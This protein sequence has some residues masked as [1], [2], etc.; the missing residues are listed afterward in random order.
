MLTTTLCEAGRGGINAC[1]RQAATTRSR[2]SSERWRTDQHSIE[3]RIG[4]ATILVSNIADGWS[5]DAERDLALAEELVLEAP[6]ARPRRFTPLSIRIFHQINHIPIEFCSSSG[7][8]GVLGSPQ[9]PRER[10]RAFNQF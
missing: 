1:L 10:A 9:V 3:T 8:E 4:L 5:S 2:L 6:S 7:P